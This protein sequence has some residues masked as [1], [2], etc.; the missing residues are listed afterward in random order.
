LLVLSKANPFHWALLWGTGK[1]INDYTI[2]NRAG[3]L[4]YSSIIEQNKDFVQC[5][6]AFVLKSGFLTKT[7][8]DEC[9]GSSILVYRP[10][11][12]YYLSFIYSPIT[13]QLN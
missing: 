3:L 6:G 10:Y 2:K 9:Y 13:L 5:S 4:T 11:R 7:S 8:I 12:I 1:C